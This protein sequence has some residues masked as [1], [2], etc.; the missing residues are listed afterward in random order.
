MQLQFLA[1]M[2]RYLG[3]M[4]HG[5][6]SWNLAKKALFVQ[7]CHLILM[8]PKQFIFCQQLTCVHCSAS[9]NLEKQTLLVTFCHVVS[10]TRRKSPNVYKSCPKSKKSP[11]L[12]TLHVVLMLPLQIILFETDD[13]SLS[14]SSDIRLKRAKN[15]FLGS[16][17]GS[18]C[19]VITSD[20][21]GQSY[22]TS[23]I[24]IYNSRVVPDLKIPHFTTLES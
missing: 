9:W 14:I 4:V 16:G 7:F 5:S 23:T 22:K 18:I 6:A 24:V 17:C 2:H 11:N 13:Q 10:V 19:R 20:T 3:I 1:S 12:V 15:Y 21:C 8:Q